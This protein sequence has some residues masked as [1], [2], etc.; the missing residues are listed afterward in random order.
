MRERPFP[1]PVGRSALLLLLVAAAFAVA[2]A[3]PS[4]TATATVGAPAGRYFHT[5]VWTGSKMIVFG[6]WNNG[7]GFANTGGIYTGGIYDD[8]GLLGP[9]QS[10]YTVAPCRLV[11]TRSPLGPTGGPA[12]GGNATRTFPMTGAACGVSST[13]L[14]VTVNVTAVGAAANGNVVLFPGDGAGPPLASTLNFLEGV[15]RANSAVVPLATDRTG[16]IRVKNNSVG[17]VHFVL[18]VNGYFQ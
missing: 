3:Q 11:D 7:S 6:G 16:S 15:T 14:A 17:T 13:A 2:E 4:W 12:L 9:P 5:A 1:G 8:P 10:F 18:D